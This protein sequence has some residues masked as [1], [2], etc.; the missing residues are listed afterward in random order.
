MRA[1]LASGKVGVGTL[2]EEL[3][4]GDYWQRAIRAV[5]AVVDLAL[6]LI[7]WTFMKDRLET[8]LVRP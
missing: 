2:A 3:V 7:K 5:K 4:T 6:S 8:E 1:L